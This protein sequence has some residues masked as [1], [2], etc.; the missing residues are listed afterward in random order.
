L[1]KGLNAAPAHLVGSSYGAYIALALSLDDPGLVRSTVLGEPPVLPL[2]S[3]TAVGEATRQ[4]L[5]RLFES[6]R[7]A[8]ESGNT[9]EGLRVFMDGGCGA[10]CFDGVPQSVR[11]A[12]VE[13]QAPAMRAERMTELAA[14]M[15]PMACDDLGKVRIPT[16]LITGERSPAFFLL[17]T[18][19]LERCLEGESHVMVPEAGHG[20][21][22]E[23]TAFYNEAL[24]DFLRR[25]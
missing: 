10:G 2:L 5:L 9:E 6:S 19:E 1:I 16:L 25:H 21:H 15:P 4:S 12:L 22:R 23:N 17:I 7:K 20:M 18:A 3:R 24:A 13:K 8:F 14:V 11:T